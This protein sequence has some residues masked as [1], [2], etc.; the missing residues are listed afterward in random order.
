ME[1]SFS[2]MRAQR[3]AM[4]SCGVADASAYSSWVWGDTWGRGKNC[5]Q[6]LARKGKSKWVEEED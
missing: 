3:A 1:I 5:V 4:D 2:A 6:R